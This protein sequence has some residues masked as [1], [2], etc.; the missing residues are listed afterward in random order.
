M[1][2]HQVGSKGELPEEELTFEVRGILPMDGTLAG[3]RGLTP[4]VPGITDAKTFNDWKQP[5]PMDISRVTKR[6]D[7]Y[8]DKY[9]ATPKAFFDLAAAREWWSSRYGSATSLRVGAADGQSLE[10]SAKS[11]E[12][13]FL[14]TLPMDSIGLA[15]QPVKFLGL[16]AA[17][18]TTDFSG[19][20]IGFSFFM[21]LS[22]LMLISL[23]VRL[24]I[25]RRASEIG[26]LSAIGFSPSRVGRVLLLEQF[27]VVLIGAVIGIVAAVGYAGL[28]IFGLRTLW[29]GAVGTTELRL[30]VQLSSLVIG[31]VGTL[32]AAGVSAWWD[33]AGCESS[34]RENSWRGKPS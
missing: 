28:L 29:V 20:F 3:D 2:Y 21:I 12:S 14:K 32:L 8:W 7:Y 24:G 13:D 4:T 6:D 11:F 33:C 5:F 34:R 16:R 27:S 23:L 15:I 18:G 26:L 9:R 19:L 25:E 22:G 31:F 30:S 17:S 1:K 10:Q